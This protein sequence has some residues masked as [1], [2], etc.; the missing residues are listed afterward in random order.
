MNEAVSSPKSFALL[1]AAARKA[2]FAQPRE[3]VALN[4]C[5]V[6]L[7]SSGSLVVSP[8]PHKRKQRKSQCS[9]LTWTWWNIP[10]M[11]QANAIDS[12]LKR[13]K[14]LTKEFVRSGPCKRLQLRGLV[15]SLEL[16]VVF[17]AIFYTTPWANVSMKHEKCT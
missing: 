5:T 15:I 11:W 10:S 12:C 9:S 7:Y 13:H 2:K 6:I 3:E 17:I 14:M 16:Q 8:W 4:R 1:L